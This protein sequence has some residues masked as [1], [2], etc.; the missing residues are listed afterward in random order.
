MVVTKVSSWRR[1][2]PSSSRTFATIVPVESCDTRVLMVSAVRG[3]DG[4]RRT[5]FLTSDAD[6]IGDSR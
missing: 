1:V 2:E 4:A 6:R 3:T 5:R